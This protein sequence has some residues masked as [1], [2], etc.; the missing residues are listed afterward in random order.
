[1]PNRSRI[2][3]VDD[4]IALGELLSDVLT[5]EGYDVTCVGNGGDALQAVDRQ[6]FH[7]ALVDLLLPG[8]DGLELMQKLTDRA[9]LLTI[10]MMSGHGTIKSAMDATR[11]GAFDWLEKPLKKERVVITVRN[12]L[13]KG[14]IL[15]EK[16]ILLREARERYA[17]VGVS[18]PMK[19]IF[20]LIDKVAR[21]DTSVLITGESGTGKELVARAVHMHS[22]RAG[23]PFI[24][25]NCAAVPETL[26]ESELFGHTKGS[27]TGA[28][29][30]KK[31]RFQLADGGTLFLDE[32][33]D[34]S[35][36]AQ[37]KLLRAIET[38]EVARVGADVPET[39]DIR[40]IAA[41]NRNLKERVRSGQFREDLF[42]RI[43]IIQIDVPPIRER[44][45]DILPILRFFT[46]AFTDDYGMD[47]KQYLPDAEAMIL[48]YEWP[49]NVRELK[50]FAEKLVVL[51]NDVKVNI[52]H[53]SLILNQPKVPY[54]DS[55]IA[56]Y[57]EAKGSFEKHF[58]LTAL[59]KNQ[60]NI[61]ETALSINMPRSL[62]Y[63][64]MEK[65]GLRG[66]S[67]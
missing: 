6:P 58:L 54:I 57:R 50:N 25:V 56:T 22:P 19:R 55:E 29:R 1:M 26:I 34:M 17:M 10:V 7:A 18:P 62:L 20:Q 41:T 12:A 51:V 44:K 31:G 43:N 36:M 33:G 5:K 45:E 42:H 59:Q 27:F 14:K 35:P 48:S 24:Q 64:K 13:E 23:A 49:G 53:V 15:M 11:M 65:Y 30:E 63:K 38:G 16:D 40:L 67:T 21:T 37:A 60:W 3:I 61:S 32:I 28:F 2:L 46:D 4:D 47:R 66:T 39:V 9:P 8:M 52:Q